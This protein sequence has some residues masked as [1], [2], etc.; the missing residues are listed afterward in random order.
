MAKEKVACASCRKGFEPHPAAREIQVTC[1]KPCRLR[2]RRKL[3]KD[4]RGKNPELSRANERQRQQRCRRKKR[5]ESPGLVT[6]AGA[7]APAAGVELRS[8]AELVLSVMDPHL[9]S[10]RRTVYSELVSVVRAGPEAWS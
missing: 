2:H 8:L 1:S 7:V 9:A 4:R 3:A 5:G 6:A 10:L